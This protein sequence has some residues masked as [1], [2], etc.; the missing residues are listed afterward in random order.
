MTNR[1]RGGISSCCSV[2]IPTSAQSPSVV[3]APKRSMR[4]RDPPTIWYSSTCRCPNATASTCSSCS[5]RMCLRRSSLTAYEE[6]ALRAFEAGA[7]D[8]L[9]KPFDD[10][11]FVRAL[12]RAKDKIAHYASTP[13]Q[14]VQRLTIRSGS[15]L[16]F[17]D[18]AD[19]DW[20][21]AAGYYA[22]LHVGAQTHI[23]RR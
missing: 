11:R 15:E 9:L 7:L 12:S 13:P 10:A 18:V 4:C 14:R 8:Y 19:I 22:C 16:L 2:A 5:A 23:L 3:R 1:S 21:E 6:H 17:L 20:I